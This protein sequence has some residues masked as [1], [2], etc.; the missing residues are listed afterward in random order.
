MRL[1]R[2][3]EGQTYTE[4]P[5]DPDPNAPQIIL[6]GPGYAAPVRT[7]TGETFPELPGEEPKSD[8][9]I[10]IGAGILLLAIVLGRR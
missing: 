2:L 1:G 10:W 8:N 5:V 7:S 6:F 9:T 4:A 3:P